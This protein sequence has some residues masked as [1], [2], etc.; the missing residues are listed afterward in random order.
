MQEVHPQQ[1]GVL[2]GGGTYKS[3]LCVRRPTQS[4]KGPATNPLK[5]ASF[6]ACIV[7]TCLLWGFHLKLVIHLLEEHPDLR[8]RVYHSLQQGPRH[9]QSNFESSR[10]GGAQLSQCNIWASISD[11][12]HS[13]TLLAPGFSTT[14]SSDSPAP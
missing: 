11:L 8:S 12:S 7:F 5:Q 9:L 14:S 3:I 6:P 13:T 4:S 2:E 10:G 1:H